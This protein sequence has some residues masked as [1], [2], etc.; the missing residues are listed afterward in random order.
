MSITVLLGN[1]SPTEADKPYADVTASDPDLMSKAAVLKTETYDPA[2]DEGGPEMVAA[3][4]QAYTTSKP[5]EGV[6]K[7]I[8]VMN[9]PASDAL[10]AFQEF[11]GALGIHYAE[12]SKPS[13]VEST[14]PTFADLI[15]K[16]YEIPVGRPD[17]WDAP[18]D[19]A[20]P[21]V[22]DDAVPAPVPADAAPAAPTAG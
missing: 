9:I 5:I 18:P 15:A 6:D 13:W 10:D 17:D 21:A 20:P 12:G 7:A 8:T 2:T 16:R 1:L 22:A 19:D 4:L 11:K 14:D 3:R